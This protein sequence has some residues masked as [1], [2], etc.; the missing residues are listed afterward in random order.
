MFCRRR[1]SGSLSTLGPTK[2]GFT[3]TMLCADFF[4]FGVVLIGWFLRAAC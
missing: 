3:T 2:A 4:V 1:M